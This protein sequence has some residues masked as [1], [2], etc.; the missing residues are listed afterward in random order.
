MAL[1][2]S[3]SVNK[4]DKKGR[5]SVPAPF[6]AALGE[7]ITDG[8]ALT[9]P[10]SRLDCIE[11]APMSRAHQRMA[12]L[13]ELD[14]DDED[15]WALAMVALGNMRQVTFDPEGRIILPEDLKEFA[16]IDDTAVF[17]GMGKTFQIWH[18]DRLTVRMAEAEEIAARL[19]KKRAAMKAKPPSPTGEN[20]DGG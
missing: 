1:F 16:G 3:R 4:V 19:P 7:E 20:G 18:P 9:K 14:E 15:H 11:A 17:V 6:R 12:Q 10:V 8:I 13:D 5:V 2:L